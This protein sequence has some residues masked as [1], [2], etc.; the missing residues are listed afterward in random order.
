MVLDHNKVATLVEVNEPVKDARGGVT[1]EGPGSGALHL[2]QETRVL[3]H[4]SSGGKTQHFQFHDVDLGKTMQV[5][6]CLII[7]RGSKRIVNHFITKWKN[8][9]GHFCLIHTDRNSNQTK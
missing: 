2:A 9:V 8:T 3:Q 6:F 1:D 7:E 4:Q 5:F